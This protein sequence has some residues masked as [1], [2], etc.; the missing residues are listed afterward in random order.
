VRHWLVTVWREKYHVAVI[1]VTDE[2]FLAWLRASFRKQKVYRL[3][4]KE[5]SGPEH[6]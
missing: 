3:T 6:Q 4:V 5:L 1:S 2:K